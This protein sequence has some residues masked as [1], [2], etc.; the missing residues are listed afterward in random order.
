[1][2]K[3]FEF[4]RL[5]GVAVVKIGGNL[6][7]SFPRFCPSDRVPIRLDERFFPINPSALFFVLLLSSGLKISSNQGGKSWGAASIE[8]VYTLSIK[9]NFRETLIPFDFT[10]NFGII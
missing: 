7:F 5:A 8:S 2:G 3:N 1:M 10:L 6:I 4:S 9:N